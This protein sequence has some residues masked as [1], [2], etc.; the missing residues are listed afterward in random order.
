M[1]Y[2]GKAVER[3][4]PELV[5]LQREGQRMMKE[6]KAS[7]IETFQHFLAKPLFLPVIPA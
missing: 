1:D 3:A 7:V 2:V 5:M 6:M 4:L